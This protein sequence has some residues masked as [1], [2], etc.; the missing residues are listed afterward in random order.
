M[1]PVIVLHAVLDAQACPGATMP[2][3]ERLPYAKRLELEAR[4]PAA[5][6]AGLCGIALVLRGASRIRGRDAPVAD[7]WF[8]TGGKPRLRGGP[9]FSVSHTARRVAV[10]VAADGELGLDLEDVG[11]DHAAGS[12]GPA[13]LDRWTATEAVLKAAGCG[14]RE[15]PGVEFDAAIGAATFAGRTYALTPLA[16]APD[17]IAHLATALPPTSVVIESIDLDG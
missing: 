1:G 7:L 4:D 12:M 14:L 13:G 6:V 3:L 15:A 11:I 8:P 16:I 10:A 2:L 5:R 17:V 9:V